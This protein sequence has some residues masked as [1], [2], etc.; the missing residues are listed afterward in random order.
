MPN[1][2]G[3]INKANYKRFINSRNKFCIPNEKH[4]QKGVEFSA[5]HYSASWGACSSAPLPTV[6]EVPWNCQPTT[7]LRTAGASRFAG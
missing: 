6:V 7:A 4:P 2:G 3:G 5:C 1:I